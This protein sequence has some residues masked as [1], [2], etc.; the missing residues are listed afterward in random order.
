M[1][2]RQGATELE[3]ALYEVSQAACFGRTRRWKDK[4]V[5][6]V[7]V[8]VGVVGGSARSRRN[9]TVWAAAHDHKA[10]TLAHT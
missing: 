6:D 8:D 10:G 4:T 1:A 7:T 5:V 3:E 2:W 9:L